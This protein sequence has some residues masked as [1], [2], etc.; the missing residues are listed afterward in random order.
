M[1]EVFNSAIGYIAGRSP[2]VPE[3]SHTTSKSSLYALD[4]AHDVSCANSLYSGDTPPSAKIFSGT[5]FRV[6]ETHYKIA[7][8]TLKRTI[9]QRNSASDEAC[10]ICLEPIKGSVALWTPCGHCFHTKC[11]EGL[12]TARNVRKK[13]PICRKDMRKDLWLLLS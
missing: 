6:P 9:L 10:A 13:C 7:S 1:I 5:E 2:P 12:A 8:R 11:M 4:L 3:E